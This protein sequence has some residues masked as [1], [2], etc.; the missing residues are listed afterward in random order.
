MNISMH[1]EVKEALQIA[2]SLNPQILALSRALKEGQLDATA[3]YLKAAPNEHIRDAVRA[4]T[5]QSLLKDYGENALFWSVVLETISG[6]V[7]LE[8]VVE[9]RVLEHLVVTPVDMAKVTAPP[10]APPLPKTTHPLRT[11]AADKTPEQKEA[12]NKLTS[13]WPVTEETPEF[14]AQRE[15]IVAL[16]A[17][18]QAAT[19]ESVLEIRRKAMLLGV[20]I[21][22]TGAYFLCSKVGLRSSCR[23][24]QRRLDEMETALGI[25]LSEL[26]KPK[27]V[28]PTVTAPPVVKNPQHPASAITSVT[29]TITPAPVVAPTGKD[30]VQRVRVRSSASHPKEA[31]EFMMSKGK[32]AVV[33]QQEI[34][35]HLEIPVNKVFNVMRNVRG[36]AHLGGGRFRM[37]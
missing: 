10:V 32:D 20:D 34:A 35:Q 17:K 27:V 11:P 37:N 22:R 3:A 26:E 29:T 8:A 19:S 1:K 18:Y 28:A 21:S 4:S 6:T 33:T 30:D 13:G 2:R 31:K 25:L 24:S 14:H 7:Q 16:A 5:V 36:A 9:N 23:Y 15:R 12:D